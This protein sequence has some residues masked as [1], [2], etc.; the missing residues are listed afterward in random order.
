[1]LENILRYPL[2]SKKL[3]IPAEI[4]VTAITG[5][6]IL[7]VPGGKLTNRG[8]IKAEIIWQ[9]VLIMMS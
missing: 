7:C 9:S 2:I 3:T 4:I 8:I 1:M 5:L 6:T